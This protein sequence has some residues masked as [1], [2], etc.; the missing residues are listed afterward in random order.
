[1]AI[2]YCCTIVCVCVTNKI[3]ELAVPQNALC[4]DR[5]FVDE[6]GSGIL[7]HPLYWKRLSM[8]LLEENKLKQCSEFDVIEVLCSVCDVVDYHRK[9]F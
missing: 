7:Y 2:T 4:E 9:Q 3:V 1:M 5:R 6:G 8:C